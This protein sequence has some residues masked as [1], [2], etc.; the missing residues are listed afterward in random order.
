[1]RGLGLRIRGRGLLRLPCR[2]S[3]QR[4]ASQENK[5]WILNPFASRVQG[6]GLR[7]QGLGLR[8]HGE[9]EG[10]SYCCCTLHTASSYCDRS[11]SVCHVVLVLFP[12]ELCFLLDS[13]AHATS[14]LTYKRRHC[15]AS[16]TTCW[17]RHACDN[18]FC[19]PPPPPDVFSTLGLK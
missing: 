19:H 14:K 11:G 5:L 9:N 7:L 4:S 18:C 15:F 10:P 13:F 17:M 8:F 12:H 2:R 1:M 3:W 16:F 6:L